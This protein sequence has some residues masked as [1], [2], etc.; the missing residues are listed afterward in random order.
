MEKIS[1]F[2]RIICLSILLQV[3][4]LIADDN[5]YDWNT[6]PSDFGG[7]G[8]MQT[9]T[10]RFAQDGTLIWGA[11]NSSPYNRLYVGMT[12]L[13][14]VEGV[15]RY[16]E[17]ENRL[18]SNSPQFSGDQSAKDKSADIKFGI[19]REGKYMPQIAIGLRDIGGTS[20]YGA[21][22]IVA[23]KVWKDF[24]FSLGLGYGLMSRR[25]NI[26]NPLRLI[27]SSF[28]NRG[29]T[30]G[31]IGGTLNSDL[32]FKGEEVTLWGGL[33]YKTSIPNL[34]LKIEYDPNDYSD[35]SGVNKQQIEVDSPLNIGIDYLLF[36][37]YYISANFQRGNEFSLNVSKPMNFNKQFGT[38]KFKPGKENLFNRNQY[39]FKNA[40]PQLRKKLT[41]TIIIQMANEGL[42]THAIIFNEDE[43]IVE[44]SQN[45]FR[46]TI[47]VIDI[48]SR[49]LAYNAPKEFKYFTVNNLDFG[50][51]NF[52]ST[53]DRDDL[54]QSVSKGPLQEEEIYINENFPN[55]EGSGYFENPYMYPHYE[56]SLR[57]NVRSVLGGPDGFFLWQLQAKLNTI[58]SFRK[59]L[60][61]ETELHQKISD[62]FDK[63]TLPSDSD[64]EHVRTDMRE[65]WKT[66]DLTLARMQL[67]YL[68]QLSPTITTRLSVGYLEEMFGGAGGEILYYNPEKRWAVGLNIYKV[69]Q[70]AYRQKFEFRDYETLTG[71]VSLYYDLP[72]YNILFKATGG[73]FLAGD[74]GIE[75]D[76]SR[77]FN[78][79]VEIG[80]RFALTNLS[81]QEY[82][83]GSFG[84]WVY[85]NIPMDI[86]SQRGTRDKTFFEWAPLVRDGGQRLKTGKDL[87]VMMK[88][89]HIELSDENKTAEHWTVSKLFS[90]FHTGNKKFN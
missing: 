80:A 42:A 44:I 41:D 16:T 49:I 57:P 89:P 73:K 81:A 9:P 87:Y 37:S 78:N 60:Y 43:I 31:G 83:E 2:T 64:I 5:L 35:E 56:W 53:I 76:L 17:I 52:S 59:G 82:G 1:L 75:L 13:P 6:F 67:D 51:T 15:V 12:I 47:S 27:S 38:E 28:K 86:F 85:G 74:K 69:K 10:A 30:T 3:K 18:Y 23:N 45:R 65:Y 25:S 54:V 33:K 72:F 84:K 34:S 48:A 11:S 4:T 7:V 21:E 36:D 19:T 8:L 88:N 22:Y 58:I 62:N 55:Y 77:R 70:R 46:S 24:D 90:G 50:M 20:D 61:L 29:K 14:W 26:K 63:W 79:G 32:W 68:H 71:H 39:F 40:G 66:G